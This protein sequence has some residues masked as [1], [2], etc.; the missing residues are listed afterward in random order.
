MLL[1]TIT[2]VINQMSLTVSAARKMHLPIDR[3]THVLNNTMKEYNVNGRKIYRTVNKT[4]YKS[5]PWVILCTSRNKLFLHVCRAQ[6]EKT[7]S[8]NDWQ[9]WKNV[10]TK[11]F[12]EL[13]EG[14]GETERAWEKL[15]PQGGL[16]E[17]D[18]YQWRQ[19]LVQNELPIKQS[20]DTCFWWKCHQRCT[21]VDKT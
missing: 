18:K 4:L 15:M 14:R 1:N 2:M 20:T 21:Y 9:C 13:E 5:F 11:L 3:Q 12:S 7:Y 6:S 17:E 10:H 8:Y 19:C 16:D